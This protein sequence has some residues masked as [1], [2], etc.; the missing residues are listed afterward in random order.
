MNVTSEVNVAV[1]EIAAMPFDGAVA[2][3]KGRPAKIEEYDAIRDAIVFLFDPK[4]N[5]RPRLSLVDG[6]GRGK[7]ILLMDG[8]VVLQIVNAG[9]MTLADI[10]MVEAPLHN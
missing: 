9:Q 4:K 6:T 5:P 10:I 8:R 7:K 1:N 3:T 2:V